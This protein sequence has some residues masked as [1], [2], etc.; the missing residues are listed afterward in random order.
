MSAI[1]QT[2]AAHA[3]VPS[4]SHVVTRGALAARLDRLP[5]SKSLW[6]LVHVNPGYDSSGVLT[7]EIDPAGDKYQELPQV[8]AFYKGL[9]ERVAAIPGVT[10]VGI[11]NTLGASTSAD[12]SVR[13]LS[14]VRSCYPHTQS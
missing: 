6:R 8:D 1:S 11:K 9:I 3:E 14:I 10:H 12:S 5:A 2:H 4:A 7:A 13:S